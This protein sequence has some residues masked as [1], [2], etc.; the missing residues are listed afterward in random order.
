M[1]RAGRG[2]PVTHTFGLAVAIATVGC[3][4]TSNGPAVPFPSPSPSTFP[5]IVVPASSP[6]PLPVC[7]SLTQYCGGSCPTYSEDLAAL[8]RACTSQ[9]RFSLY[10]TIHC[11]GVFYRNERV[12]DSARRVTEAY[13][14][15]NGVMIGARASSQNNEFCGGSTTLVSAGTILTCPVPEQQEVLCK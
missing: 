14:D 12:E 6:T 15:G 2:A 5:V 11:P 8:R 10:S 4:Y 9:P 7:T 1:S 3:D 13:F